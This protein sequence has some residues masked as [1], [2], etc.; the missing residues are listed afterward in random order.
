L[1]GFV[2]GALAKLATDV[3]LMLATEVGGM[4]VWISVVA[5]VDV[6]AETGGRQHI[7]M[8][9]FVH[10]ACPRLGM[11]PSNEPTR[12]NEPTR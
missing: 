10:P 3:K 5:A 4:S 7:A 9:G 1:P 12:Q 2:T 8:A 6:H 11:S